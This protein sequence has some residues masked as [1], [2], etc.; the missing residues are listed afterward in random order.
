MFVVFELLIDGTNFTLNNTNFFDINISTGIITN[1]TNLSRTEIHW[2][3][4]NV[5]DKLAN[6]RTSGQFFINITSVVTLVITNLTLNDM[7]IGYNNDIF[8][9][10]NLDISI[11]YNFENIDNSKLNILTGYNY[12]S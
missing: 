8:D 4:V 5:T 2:L 3:I 1:N 10:D 9:N 6:E 11:G 7:I 12:E